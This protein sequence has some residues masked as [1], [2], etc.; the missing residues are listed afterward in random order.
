MK[1][2]SNIFKPITL[3]IVVTI[4]AIGYKYLI[5][6]ISWWIVLSPIL[7]VIGVLVV[8]LIIIQWLLNQW[9]K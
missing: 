2:N 9:S 6:D 8:A 3:A 1:I 7:I 4:M 5:E